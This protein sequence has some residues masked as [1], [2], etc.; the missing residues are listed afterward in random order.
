MF[1]LLGLQV[2]PHELVKFLNVSL[3]PAV[4]LI[5]CARPLSVFACM[6]FSNSTIR[7]KLFISWVGLKGA[8][9]IVFAFI[10]VLQGVDHA[11]EIFNMVF[12]V[13]LISILTQGTTIGVL[14]RLLRLEAKE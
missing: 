11:D 2:F 1:I 10:P 3:L 13:V 14:A 5:L 12:F 9:P 4:F 8:T 7:K 6:L